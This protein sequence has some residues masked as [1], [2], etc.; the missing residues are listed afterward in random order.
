[1]G[2]E[3]YQRVYHEMTLAE[4]KT[5]IAML[6][7]EGRVQTRKQAKKDAWSKMKR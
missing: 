3:A 7:V 6:V 1:M 4:A 2:A 5:Y